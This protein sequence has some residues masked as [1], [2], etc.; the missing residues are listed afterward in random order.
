[1]AEV[2]GGGNLM[3]VFCLIRDPRMELIDRSG[4]GRKLEMVWM[5]M[6]KCQVGAGMHRELVLLPEAEVLFCVD[7]ESN[8]GK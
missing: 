1:M 7:C 8:S 2:E 4:T 3:S 5:M 6:T